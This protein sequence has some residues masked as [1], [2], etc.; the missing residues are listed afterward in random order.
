MKKLLALAILFFP[1]LV[2]AQTEGASCKP[3]QDNINVPCDK[4]GNL[5]AN[6]QRGIDLVHAA[7]KNNPLVQAELELFGFAE[8]VLANPTRSSRGNRWY[9]GG[10]VDPSF[11]VTNSTTYGTAVTAYREW[12][13]EIGVGIGRNGPTANFN[14]AEAMR[15]E[16]QWRTA[17]QSSTTR[18]TAAYEVEVFDKKGSSMLK[19]TI[20]RAA[21]ARVNVVYDKAAEDA[22]YSRSSTY[23]NLSCRPPR[24]GRRPGPGPRGGAFG[25]GL[26]SGGF[27]IPSFGFGG[28]G[29][30]GLICTNYDIGGRG[31]GDL[32]RLVVTRCV[33]G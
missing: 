27:S 16:R 17:V 30:G 22:E 15:L 32:T 6:P 21:P 24:D 5:E 11:T 10:V 26:L 1:M 9:R 2:L 13:T 33:R 28:G 7:A 18:G 4:C 23:Q 20:S 19:E 8:V 25:G 12:R 3:P 29:G 14:S 31:D